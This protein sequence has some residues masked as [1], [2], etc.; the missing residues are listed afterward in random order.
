[1]TYQSEPKDL[2]IYRSG[3][4]KDVRTNKKHK[5][6]KNDENDD[7]ESV[8]SN[9]TVDTDASVDVHISNDSIESNTPPKK[10]GFTGKKDKKD[11]KKEKKDEKEKKTSSVFLNFFAAPDVSGQTINQRIVTGFRVLGQRMLIVMLLIFLGINFRFAANKFA[12]E[13]YFP[14]DG[15]LPPY[16]PTEEELKEI[17]PI[18]DLR[19]KCKG[20]ETAEYISRFRRPDQTYPE[21]L[22]YDGMILKNKDPCIT[23]GAT[24]DGWY[25]RL[26]IQISKL[27]G[28]IGDIFNSMINTFTSLFTRA[29]TGVEDIAETAVIEP[30][31][32]IARQAEQLE[33]DL[34]KT[35]KEAEAQAFAEKQK[36]LAQT[37]QATSQAASQS[38]QKVNSK[39]TAQQKVAN[40]NRPTIQSGKGKS[41]IQTGGAPPVHRFSKFLNPYGFD[42][43]RKIT[44]LTY[45]YRPIWAKSTQVS[46]TFTNMILQKFL[47]LFKGDTEIKES[48]GTFSQ[49]LNILLFIFMSLI[50]LIG[51][52]FTIPFATMYA[53][54]FSMI[55]IVLA[56]GGVP[57][58]SVL[59]LG[60]SIIGIPLAIYIGIFLGFNQVVNSGIIMW[61]FLYFLVHVVLGPLI[62]LK[63]GKEELKEFGDIIRKDL[64]GFFALTWILF[65]FTA[66]QVAPSGFSNGVLIGGILS[67]ILFGFA[68]NA[69][70][71]TIVDTLSTMNVLG[72]MN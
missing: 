44:D 15:T 22:Y 9:G 70:T 5:N 61:R 27:F 56:G 6:D 54:I 30:E 31:M 23:E 65:V 32:N 64:N 17:E 58:I 72:V 4:S 10:E 57:A 42:R 37:A 59:L 67:P 12:N 33:A 45:F 34:V 51:G 18:R 28:V 38:P 68:M 40:L 29:V 71:Q 43:E 3:H 13:D 69:S 24:S 66:Y 62:S 7:A 55:S 41:Y 47:G 53:W 36:A 60:M 19:Q 2:S 20:D 52:A 1:M 14:T 63:Q 11:D 16:Y 35:T 8:G 50:V 49:L 48:H 39:L 25:I 46:A 21:F 26:S